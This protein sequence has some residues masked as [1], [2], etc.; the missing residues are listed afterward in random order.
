MLDEGM[1]GWTSYDAARAIDTWLA[2]NPDIHYWLLGWGT[3]DALQ[4]TDPAQFR[5][6][7]QLVITKIRAAGHTP[8]LALIPAYRTASP[9]AATVN[10]KIR[11]LNAQITA[12][13]QANHLI[14]GP[15][16]YTIFINHPNDYYSSDGVHPNQAGAKAMNYAWFL[17]MKR[18]L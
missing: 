18:V 15:D 13:T 9:D 7:L 10:A 12:L 14:A 11:A 2:L 17:V 16:L 5:A 4:G 3:N 6:N 8:V 1:E